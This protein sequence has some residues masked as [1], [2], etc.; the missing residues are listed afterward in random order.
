QGQGGGLQITVTD[1]AGGLAHPRTFRFNDLGTWSVVRTMQTLTQWV[2]M[3]S[4]PHGAALGWQRLTF[5]TDAGPVYADNV[6]EVSA[7]T[8]GPSGVDNNA[9]TRDMPYLTYKQALAMAGVGDTIQL[10]D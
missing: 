7:I 6:V 9:G 10:K 8:A 3:V 4:V 2:L 1:P 5:D